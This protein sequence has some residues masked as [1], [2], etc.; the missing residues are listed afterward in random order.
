MDGGDGKERRREGSG[1]IGNQLPIQKE[2]SKINCN[3][4]DD[5]GRIRLRSLQSIYTAAEF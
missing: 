3:H 2:K 5:D 4:F 1:G